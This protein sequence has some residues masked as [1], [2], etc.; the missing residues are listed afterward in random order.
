MHRLLPC[1]IFSHK[2]QP[3]LHSTFKKRRDS[4][5]GPAA[6]ESN[7]AHSTCPRF[8]VISFADM[9]KYGRRGKAMSDR[10]DN[11]HHKSSERS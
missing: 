6:T 3:S 5:S 8:G 9:V 10:C 2:G 4:F 7:S 11:V 1:V